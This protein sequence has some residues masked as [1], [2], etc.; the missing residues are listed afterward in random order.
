MLFDQFFQIKN[1]ILVKI[2]ENYLCKIFIREWFLAF[3]VVLKEPKK[4][5]QFGGQKA[6]SDPKNFYHP[7]PQNNKAPR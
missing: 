6:M 3:F 7:Y 5:P 4:S 1:A 2:Y